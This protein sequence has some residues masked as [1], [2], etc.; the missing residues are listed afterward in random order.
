MK[1]FLLLLFF[2]SG[3]CGLGYEILW[4]RYLELIFGNTT[5]SVASIL[6]AFMFGFATGSYYAGK[7]TTNLGFKAFYYYL[8]C[9]LFIGI[10][11]I[12]SPFVLQSLNY[13]LIIL[14]RIIG[15]SFYIMSCAKFILAIIVLI[16]PTFLMGATFPLMVEAISNLTPK[17]SKW[18]SIL[19]G[20]NLVGAGTFIVLALYIFLPKLTLNGTILLFAGLNLSIFTI[21]FIIF[22]SA[23]I[24][25]QQQI[26]ISAVPVRQPLRLETKIILILYLISGI[27]SFSF[28]IIWTR[29]YILLT[30]GSIYSFG[31]ILFSWILGLGIGSFLISTFIEKIKDYYFTFAVLQ[32]IISL[33][34]LA[35]YIWITLTP[36]FY[37]M[38]YPSTGNT[39]FKDNLEFLWKFASKF[40]QYSFEY[41]LIVRTLLIFIGVF[42]PTICFG[43]ILPVL[44]RGFIIS[45]IS[46]T[47]AASLLYIFNCLG[48]VIGSWIT[49]FIL[50][51]LLGLKYTN[52]VLSF[53]CLI[54]FFVSL[55][56]L[57]RKKE[58]IKI[59]LLTLG[60]ILVAGVMYYQTQTTDDALLAGT[61]LYGVY[62]KDVEEFI[63]SLEYKKRLFLY[64]G[65]TGI[66]DVKYTSQ[67]SYNLSL[68][69]NGKVDA[70][71]YFDLE[72][73][74]FSGHLGFFY[75]KNVNDVLV[76]G[77]GSG[78]TAGSVSLHKSIKN[79]YIVEIEKGVVEAAKKY[80]HTTNYN[81]LNNPK[82]QLIIDD[83][84]SFIFFTDK[85]FDLIISEPSN[86][87]LTGASNLFTR[88]FF[89]NVKNKSSWYICPVVSY[90]SFKT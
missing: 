71:S 11:A 67:A 14:H 74:V 34:A 50:I 13:P 49:S 5:F 45:G 44:L 81:V 79:I 68:S 2:I 7:K 22:K 56:F 20:A 9:E 8:L 36:Y 72:T 64:E 57:S 86:P 10:F 19:Y 30:G 23:K 31:M 47:K 77:L 58:F 63:K 83:G 42:I 76:I 29:Y 46:P 37:M 28:E 35:Q 61:Y 25:Y 4:T 66:V 60:V 17:R 1:L 65:L 62:Y 38:V 32:L 80:F 73:Q 48:A 89:I 75:H 43:A 15:K 88:E 6:S 90:L 87:W 16:I 18:S 3:G 39:F 40:F 55:E 84:R 82:V 51:P 59:I 70:S 52:N 41:K 26:N 12:I 21:G 24:A 69:I 27:C 78:V 53:L 54:I 85:K 33:F